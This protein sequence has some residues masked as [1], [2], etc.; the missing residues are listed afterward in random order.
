MRTETFAPFVVLRAVDKVR[1]ESVNAG[2][3]LF[4]PD[5]VMVGVAPTANRIKALHPDFAAVSLAAWREGLQSALK[6]FAV[7]LPDIAQQIAMLPLLCQPFTADTEPGSALLNADNPQE[8]LEALLTWQVLTR[9]ATV[10]AKNGAP[11][12]P[13][14]LAAQMRT[15]FRNAKVFSSNAEDLSKGRVI[16]NFP[17]AARDDLYADFA[18]KNGRLHVLETLDLRGVDHITAS[19][20]GDAAVKGITL[21]EARTAVDGER[22]AVV[23]ASAFE[24]ARPAIKMVERYASNVYVLESPKDKQ[25][26]VDFMHQ[27]LHNDSLPDLILKPSIG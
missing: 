16:A 21:D 1:G 4:T 3:V 11:K 17:V 12:R 18:V 10:R 13:T 7:K 27:A 26:F 14:K 9:Q 5:G 20:R 15:W 24:I 8:T 23:S 19:I 22:I 2:I 6:S 25:A